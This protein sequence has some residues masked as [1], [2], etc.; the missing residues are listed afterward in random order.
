VVEDQYK[1]RPTELP[2]GI[3]LVCGSQSRFASAALAHDV[4]SPVKRSLLFG[5]SFSLILT[6]IGIAYLGH[7]LLPPWGSTV[8]GI[9][10]VLVGGLAYMKGRTA[11]P[12]GWLITILAWIFGLFASG[13]FYA[14]FF[15]VALLARGD[16]TVSTSARSAANA[17]PETRQ[18]YRIV[19][20][21]VTIKA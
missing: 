4:R 7:V 18:A 16:N 5:A 11:Q 8:T 12:A 19:P 14:L 10:A 1:R 17:A 9:V 21:W 20:K 3:T 13:L 6:G 15:Y 2:T